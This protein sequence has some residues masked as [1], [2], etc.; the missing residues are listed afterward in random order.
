MNEEKMAYDQLEKILPFTHDILTTTPCV[1]PNSYSY[2]VEEGMDGESMS[3]W[4]TGSANTLIKTLIK[5]SFGIEPNL[6]G[7]NI[8]IKN[9]YPSEKCR[10]SL[11]VNNT[12]IVVS[13]RKE[14]LIERNILLN[15]KKIEKNNI[16]IGDDMLDKTNKI[17]I[18]IVE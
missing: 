14:N 16:F 1:M 10:C 17:S 2:N 3:D 6:N 4:Y 12:I 5:G 18:E 15:G 7:V 8:N 9:Y 11:K 13:Y